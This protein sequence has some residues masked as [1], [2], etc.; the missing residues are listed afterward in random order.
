M[1]NPLLDF[2]GLPRFLEIEP[3]HIQSALDHL[4]DENRARIADLTAK[5]TLARW[6]NFAK[7]LAIMDER[8]NR[9]WSIVS[10]LNAVNNSEEI[11]AVYE[12]ALETFTSYQTEV[13]QNKDL[14]SG[15]T[16]IEANDEF[17]MLNRAQQK[18]IRN[19]SQTSPKPSPNRDQ[20]GLK[21]AQTRPCA[22]PESNP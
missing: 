8:L 20:T 10:H 1:A 17:G 15:F 6:D 21:P 12:I 14:F 22:R 13:S 19:A 18:T 3:H 2:T 16:C 5:P 7:P 4:L 9:L 11:R